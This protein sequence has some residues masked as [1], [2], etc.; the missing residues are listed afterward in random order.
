MNTL[1]WKCKIPHSPP[2][3]SHISLGHLFFSP[4]EFVFDYFPFLITHIT[5]V[6]FI[7]TM[8][9]AQYSYFFLVF[10][11][12]LKHW[13]IHKSPYGEHLGELYIAGCRFQP[14]CFGVEKILFCRSKKLRRLISIHPHFE[15]SNRNKHCILRISCVKGL[16]F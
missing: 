4:R 11:H 10:R 16:N 3:L 5:R 13:I 7:H 2:L 14:T 1:L 8:I 15:L 9:L 12:P 6:F